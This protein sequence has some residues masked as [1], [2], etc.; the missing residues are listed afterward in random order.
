MSQTNLTE[1]DPEARRN[2]SNP[3]SELGTPKILVVDDIASNLRLICDAIESE[4]YNIFVAPNAER[5]LAIVKRS[6]PDLIIL[7]IMMPDMDGF[8]VCQRLKSDDTTANIP[9]IFV[10]AKDEKEN[11][12]KGFS[13]GGVDYIT[14]PFEKEEVRIRVKTHLQLAQLTKTLQEKND[15]L[16]QRNQ[17]LEREITRRQSAEAERDQV[18]VAKQAVDERVALLSKREAGQ[19]GIENF[20]GKS[21]AIQKILT[22][23]ERLQTAN[24]TSVLITG[25]SG[26]GKEL[27]ARAIHHGGI[28]STNPFVPV[29]C[30]AIP[31]ELAE[32][33]LFGHVRGAFTGARESRKG[34]FELANGGTL[35]LDEIGD[36]PL[37]LQAKLLRT[38]EDGTIMPIGASKEK[39][40]DVRLI[41]ATNANIQAQIDSGVF[42]NDLYHRLATFPVNAPPLRERPEDIPLLARHFLEM[43][44]REMGKAQGNLSD[45][46]LEALTSYHFPGNVRELKNIIERALI[47]SDGQVIREK[48]LNLANPNGLASPQYLAQPPQPY[49][50]EP[51]EPTIPA[52]TN[53][54]LHRLTPEE[55]RI[56][57]YVQ[58]NGSINN[59]E[60][61]QMLEVDRYRA[62]YLLDKL[63]SENLLVRSGAFRAARYYLPES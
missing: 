31:A 24:T 34:Y 23:V 42:R 15:A 51:I 17:E 61:R 50:T 12:I 36:M 10:T 26:T 27:I 2:P 19:W 52:E 63:L 33:M 38:L 47:V 32:S 11:L 21:Q 18:K 14:K 60:C 22:D 53:A 46:A 25:E 3:K 28:R 45:A 6:L 30:S 43:F 39:R 37:N 40:V 56:L 48:D 9:V 59:T 44:A 41:A 55:T 57:A 58:R 5:A 4:S 49:Q 54:P 1:E 13:V 16:A 62:R 29:N 35:F 8:E 7:D 20:I